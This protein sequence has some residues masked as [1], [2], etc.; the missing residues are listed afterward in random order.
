MKF[1]LLTAIAGL[2]KSQ[3]LD[4]LL[5]DTL[6]KTLGPGVANSVSDRLEYK[7]RGPFINIADDENVKLDILHW[8]IGGKLFF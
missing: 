7:F 5:N 3:Q 1:F 6:G 2:A 8:V 4:D